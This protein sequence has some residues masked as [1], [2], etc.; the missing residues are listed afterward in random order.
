MQ[1]PPS[2]VWTLTDWTHVS[3]PR[4]SNTLEAVKGVLSE[5]GPLPVRQLISEVLARFPVSKTA[6]SHCLSASPEIG[7]LP[8]RRVGLVRN[9][10]TFQPRRPLKMPSAVIR[11]EQHKIIEFI[12]PV[13]SQLLR[14]S[15]SALPPY[16]GAAIG[17]WKY[18]DERQFE[19]G[20]GGKLVCRRQ[21]SNW[22]ISSL[23][24]VLT[25]LGAAAGDHL[26]L[27]MNLLSNDCAVRLRKR[28]R[29]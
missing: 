11:H 24:D 6:V 29:A 20:T 3:K 19:L 4:F 21:I 18:G 14:G 7:W 8:D 9:G 13:D 2:G 16:V 5:L 17:L 1:I 12:K 23:K 27:T 26:V 15:G 22:T 28:T 25:V 10:A